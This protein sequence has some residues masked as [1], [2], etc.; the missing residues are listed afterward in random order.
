M[1][2]VFFLLASVALLAVS[3]VM[4]VKTVKPS[5]EIVSKSY[6]TA[7]FTSISAATS[8]TLTYVPGNSQSIE[9]E[10]PDNYIDKLQVEVSGSMLKVY[11]KDLQNVNYHGSLAQVRVSA[12]TVKAL[13]SSAGARIICDST[14][15]TPDF[16]ATVSSGGGLSLS[17]VNCTTV[18]I[19]CSSGGSISIDKVVATN[20][21]ATASSGASCSLSGLNG[22]TVSA[23][24]SS[25]ASMSLSGTIREATF[26]TSSGASLNASSLK[27]ETGS[28]SASSASTLKCS[29]LNPTSTYSNSGAS[30]SNTA[31]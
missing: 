27:A 11:F 23:T 25:G 18:T 28:A 8:V 2:K 31:K 1:K 26:N 13:H 3:C 29:I 4:P 6:D 19:T 5:D 20:T 30:I 16:N 10:C 15:E 24:L 7:S 21:L 12:P 22:D 9:V 14:L 17:G